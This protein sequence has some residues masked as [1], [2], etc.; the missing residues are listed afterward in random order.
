MGIVLLG[1][2]RQMLPR[3]ERPVLRRQKETEDSIFLTLI[4]KLAACRLVIM[5]WINRCYGPLIIPMIKFILHPV[6]AG[7]IEMGWVNLV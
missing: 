3:Q 4:H 6:V 7:G 2:G 1:N 5:Y